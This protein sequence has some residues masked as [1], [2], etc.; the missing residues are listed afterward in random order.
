[1]VTN[2]WLAFLFNLRAYSAAYLVILGHFLLHAQ[3][4][5]HVAQVS[6]V[7]ALTLLITYAATKHLLKEEN[8]TVTNLVPLQTPDVCI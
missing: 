7:F 6:K 8:R 5:L 4:S 1:M 2:S 3:Q